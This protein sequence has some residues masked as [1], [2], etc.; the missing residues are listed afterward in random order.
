MSARAALLVLAV[1]VLAATGFTVYAVL[2]ESALAGWV[3]ALI[4]ASVL[5]KTSDGPSARE[6]AA[7]DG[8]RVAQTGAVAGIGASALVIAGVGHP[9]LVLLGVVAVALTLRGSASG[10]TSAVP[11]GWR[12]DAGARLSR[13]ALTVVLLLAFVVVLDLAETGP[14]WT[15]DVAAVLRGV[16]MVAALWFAAYA[17]AARDA[18]G[19]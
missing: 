17:V 11:E 16:V 4:G 14:S 13:F 15:P 19:D 5:A 8:F 10:L 2:P 3:V 6:G 7:R 1:G 12:A 18:V 9:A